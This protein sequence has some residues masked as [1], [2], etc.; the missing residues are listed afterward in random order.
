MPAIDQIIIAGFIQQ[1]EQAT[2]TKEKGDALEKLICYVFE[3]IPG[4]KVV[5][6]NERNVFDTEEIDVALFNDKDP[7]GAPFLPWIILIECK[8]WSSTV[9]SEQV[10]WFDTKLRNRGVELGILVAAN[11]I[12]GEKAGRTDSHSTIANALRDGRRMIVFTIQEIKT[13]NE[14]DEL[15]TMIKR[16]LCDLVITGKVIPAG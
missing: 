11:G 10:A 12:S 5:S 7:D 3:T 4:I 1:G 14:S 13:I 16:K 8:N 2:T 15:L 6:R 9:G